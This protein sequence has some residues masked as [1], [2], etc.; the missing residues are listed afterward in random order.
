MKKTFIQTF[1]VLTFILIGGVF[2]DTVLADTTITCT[3]TCSPSYAG[4]TGVYTI[5]PTCDASSPASYDWKLTVN[6]VSVEGK[7]TCTP[8]SCP[9]YSGTDNLT[10]TCVY[11]LNAPITASGASYTSNSVASPSGYTGSRTW[12]CNN[13][14]WTQGSFTCNAPVATPTGFSVSTSATCGGNIRLAWNTNGATGYDIER[15]NSGTWTNVGNVSSYT[16]TVAVGSAHSYRVRAWTTGPGAGTPTASSG[17]NASAAC[18]VPVNGG[19]TGWSSCSAS[20]GGG[21]QSRSC[22]NPTP[23]NGGSSCSGSASQACNTQACATNCPATTLSGCV[24]TSTPYGLTK[25]GSC[26]STHTGTGCSYMCGA[27]GVWDTSVGSFTNNCTANPTD[28][29]LTLSNLPGKRLVF[30]A[31]EGSVPVEW[32]LNGNDPSDCS[33]HT[34]MAPSYTS[35]TVVYT[36][37]VGQISNAPIGPINA[38]LK[39]ILRCAG[40]TDAEVE[41][42]IMPGGWES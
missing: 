24:L 1:V 9:A 4:V 39:F 27:G 16:D 10:G 11:N 42:K 17:A 6:G 20:C 35:E 21:T 8:P 5:N 18:A 31:A 37:L 38:A 22:T 29:I 23:A 2:P 28:P 40:M 14:V 3:T 25:N 41:V 32:T 19:W 34:S 15:D 26:A 30:V 33:L 36:S 7:K 13:G 12:N